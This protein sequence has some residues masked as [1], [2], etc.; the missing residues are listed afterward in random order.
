MLAIFHDKMCCNF[1]N[2]FLCILWDL[3]VR[4][5][6][7]SGEDLIKIVKGHMRSTCQKLK[8]Q[9]ILQVISRLGQ[10]VRCTD[11]WD[12]KCN[13][14]ALHPYYIYP[15]YPQNCKEAYQIENPREISTTPYLVRESYSSS[16]ENLFVISSPSLLPLTYLGRRFVHKY[17]PHSN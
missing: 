14:Y 12:F 11:S 2:L 5:L 1:I 9:C 16:S 8:S 6:F 3:I 10:P 13:F 4:G 17:N 15:H 7:F